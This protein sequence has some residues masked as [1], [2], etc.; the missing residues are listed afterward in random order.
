MKKI[1]LLVGVLALAALVGAGCGSNSSPT[2]PASSQV[3]SVGPDLKFPDSLTVD[4]AHLLV[5]VTAAVQQ[6]V[7]VHAITADWNEGV[8]TWNSL[9]GSFDPMAA[10]TFQVDD[11]GWHAVDI[12][13]LVQGWIDGSVPMYGVLLDQVEFATPRTAYSSREVAGFKPM[14]MVA[15]TD[16]GMAVCD[17]LAAA[18]DACITEDLP[19]MNYGSATALFTG[20]EAEAGENQ[21]LIRFLFPVEI[22]RQAVGDFIWNDANANG[23]Q[24]STELGLADIMVSLYTCSDS[25]IGTAQTDADGYYVMRGKRPLGL[26]PGDYYLHFS[27]PEGWLFSP[28]NEGDD[29]ELDSDADPMTGK[30]ACFTLSSGQKDLS[31]DAGL[32]EPGCTYSKGFWKNHAGFGPQDDLVT[33]LLPLWLGTEDGD[34]SLNV[35]T[36]EMAVALLSQKVYGCPSNGI[37]KLYAQLLAAK[38]NVANGAV[39]ADIDDVIS[40]A[41]TFLSD[42]D[43]QDWDSLSKAD[44]KMVLC[45]KGKLDLYNNGYTGPGHCDDSHCDFDD[46]DKDDD[47]DEEDG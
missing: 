40:D 25:L 42:Y 20:W 44:R 27:A 30:T 17:T 35:E 24:D 2:G 38:L 23:I 32:Y 14:L 36:A 37:T 1:V 13:G 11:T 28:Q 8:V 16:S 46:E 29:P 41:D 34:K 39:P 22:P 6:P 45:W 10:G 9:A 47:E 33:D 21:S 7:N 15:Y 4:S 3:R 31:R 26:P 43:W 18:A 19:D 5:Y 12:T